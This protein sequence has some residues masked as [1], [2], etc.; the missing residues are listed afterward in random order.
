MEAQ[1]QLLWTAEAL[2]HPEAEE[3]YF[4]FDPV[5][6]LRDIDFHSITDAGWGQ[7]KSPSPRAVAKLIVTPNAKMEDIRKAFGTVAAKGGYRF[8][9]VTVRNP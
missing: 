9:E 4:I 3:I 2:T 7:M 6:G 5:M 1:G 8:I